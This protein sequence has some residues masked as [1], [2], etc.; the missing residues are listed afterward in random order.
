MFDLS[1]HPYFTE[2]I[3]P[4]SGVK[5]YVLT[6]EKCS[7]A[8]LKL[9]KENLAPGVSQAYAVKCDRAGIVRLPFGSNGMK[10]AKC[11]DF[12]LN[13]LKAYPFT[14]G[15]DE[16]VVEIMPDACETWIVFYR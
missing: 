1:K 7:I 3:D 11:A 15:A 6:D 5:S 8:W 14:P 4:Q 13:P 10:C 16:T 2:Y 12:F 9:D